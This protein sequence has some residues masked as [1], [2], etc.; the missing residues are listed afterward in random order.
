MADPNKVYP[1]DIS[2]FAPAK[3]HN[4]EPVKK[5]WTQELIDT[6]R[7]MHDEQEDYSFINNLGGYNNH[8]M[9]RARRV[10]TK[11][12]SQFAADRSAVRDD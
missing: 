8:N 4:P 12:G 9:R 5:D 11:V 10:L 7:A 1:L 2:E 6:L 3:V